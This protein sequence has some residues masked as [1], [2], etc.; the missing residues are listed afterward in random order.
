MHVLSVISDWLIFPKKKNQ[1]R[2]QPLDHIPEL[3]RRVNRLIK[4][5][6]RS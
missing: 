6:C 1:L 3:S 5:V 2:E 4:D